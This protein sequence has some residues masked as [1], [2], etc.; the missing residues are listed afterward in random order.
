MPRASV[1][2][3]SLAILLVCPL[4][5]SSLPR[6]QAATVAPSPDP[7]PRTVLV[8]IY[9]VDVGDVSQQD[10]SYEADFYLSFAWNG[11]W[12]GAGGN[13]SSALPQNFAILNGQISQ[14]ELV[15]SDDNING[16]SENYLSYRVYATLFSPMNFAR[17]PLDHQTLSIMVEDNDYENSSLVF[18]ADQKSQLDQGVQ[19]PGWILDP[20][21]VNMVVTNDV[22]KTTFGY[23]GI[24]PT[25]DSYYSEAVFSMQVHRPF[26]DVTLN[27]LLPL[28]VL[29]AL[30]M[31]SFRIKPESFEARLEVG[32]ISIFT[33]VA[34]LLALNSTLPAQDYVTLADQLLMVAFAVLIY[35]IAIAILLHS[36]A[37]SGIPRWAERLDR[38]SFYA[39]PLA[40]LLSFLI[41]VA[42]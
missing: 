9:V 23:P 32:V 29:V 20:G 36:Y 22:Y 19:I 17:Y 6:A 28:A 42:F 16:T 10:G 1:V 34:F 25:T 18:L 15:S 11:T 4:V 39:V 37:E 30:A 38:V 24:S 33:A 2:V 13:Q 7:A 40:A 5:F 26:A 35:A 31:A 41:L 3:L 14:L 12:Y 8:D 27:V 21:S